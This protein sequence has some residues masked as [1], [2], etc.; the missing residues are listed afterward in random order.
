MLALATACGAPEADRS[1]DALAQGY[2]RAALQLAQ[3]Q[4]E[5]VERWAGPQDWR[6][7]PREPVA[8]TRRKI[9]ALTAALDGIEHSGDI[10]IDR[11]RFAYLRGQLTALDV[12]AGRLLGE[13]TGFAEE[14]RRA[15]VL[16]RLD[17]IED[18][19]ARVKA[20]L[21]AAL[22]GT[23]PIRARHEAFR[24]RFAV[25][26]ERRELVLREAL[27]ACREAT[28]AHVPLPPDEGLT[29][30]FDVDSPWDGEARYDGNHRSTID[31]S[32]RGRM[33]V[34]RAVTLACHEGY[35]GH[36]VQQLLIEGAL[37][38]GR[39][40]PEFQL[41]PRFGPHLLITEGA[42]EA[43][44]TLVLPRDA[45][46]RLYRDRLLPMA[47]L[48]PEAAATLVDVEERVRDADGAIPDAIAAYLDSRASRDDTIESLG[49]LGV[50]DP[51]A[52]VRF[53]ERRRTVAVVYPVG[54]RL[55]ERHLQAGHDPWSQ[56][57]AL[58]TTAPFTLQ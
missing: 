25:P 49:D 28:R 2:V 8:D 12:A 15:F 11:F 9:G 41:A 1:L 42:G 58:F 17:V 22:P 4:P 39:Q 10:A 48:P 19:A 37:V 13:S 47:G 40:W 54:R 26:L 43:G 57:V 53:A 50:I 31:I 18:G 56:L 5:L 6:P 27:E 55:V 20:A 44:V 36:H 33:D 46:L 51:D 16:D 52:F 34:T 24:S 21:A 29:L 45:R 35:P 14:M 7:G 23:G 38:Q 3:H 30:R 32:G